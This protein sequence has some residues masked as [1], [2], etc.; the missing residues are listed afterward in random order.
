MTTYTSR[1]SIWTFGTPPHA[2]HQTHYQELGRHL[3]Q[4]H[5]GPQE[6]YRRTVDTQL[7]PD[8]PGRQDRPNGKNG[9]PGAV[10]GVQL[11]TVFS[12][13]FKHKIPIGVASHAALAPVARLLAGGSQSLRIEFG[14]AASRICRRAA[15]PHTL[16]TFRPTL[17]EARA[18]D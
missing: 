12:V 11:N 9:R 13:G 7:R 5:V 8:R 4:P 16:S 1:L 17:G 10:G 2:T 3:R 6:P 18:T 15:L 14:L